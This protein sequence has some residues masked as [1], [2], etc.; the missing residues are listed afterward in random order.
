LHYAELVENEN[1]CPDCGEP[2]ELVEQWKTWAVA[3]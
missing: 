3:Q 1:R 2:H